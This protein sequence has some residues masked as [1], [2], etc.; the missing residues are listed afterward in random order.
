MAEVYNVSYT[1]ETIE[2]LYIKRKESDDLLGALF[3]LKSYEKLTNDKVKLYSYYAD[4]YYLL[5]Q[6]EKSSEYWCKYLC[7]LDKNPNDKKVYV[8]DA[9]DIIS[10]I[11]AMCEG[12]ENKLYAKAYAGLGA[13]YYKSGNKKTAGYYINKELKLSTEAFEPYSDVVAEFVEKVTSVEENYRLA[14]PYDKADFTLL[15]EE[16]ENLYKTGEYD[17]AIQSLNVIPKTSRFYAEKCAITALCRYLTDDVDGAI[18]DF[19]SALE[20]D[21]I[22][23]D[24]LCNA[25]SILNKL[26]LNEK[27]DKYFNKLKLIDKLDKEDTYKAI[28][29]YCELGEDE[30]ALKSADDY[31]KLNYYDANIILIL[32]QVY[33][34]KQDY[35]RAIKL[36]NKAYELSESFVSRFYRNLADKKLNGKDAP[37]KLEYSF[38]VPEYQREKIT[39]CITKFLKEDVKNFTNDD[40]ELVYYISDYAFQNH[41]YNI[42]SAMVKVLASFSDERSHE[43]LANLLVKLT[44]YDQIKT[45]ILGF[46]TADGYE[47][48]K[49]SV[50]SNI[51]KTIKFEKLV[52]AGSGGDVML[53]AYALCFAKIAPLEN[54]LDKLITTACV[55]YNTGLDF[56][57]FK[58]V[59]SLSAVI[60]ELSKIKPIISR[61]D[62]AKFFGANLKE[63]KRIKQ[64]FLNAFND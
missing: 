29:V 47:G 34:N 45:G 2:K 39:K 33:Y 51:Y 19:E 6:Y 3:A 41:S 53:E 37:N 16:A 7:E 22:N 4:T 60:F 48:I 20:G 56:T 5:N 32:G 28:L 40:I 61:R 50:F 59:N 8:A 10:Q 30:L 52:F 25:I 9:N 31:L 63:V 26:G 43:Y 23:V 18:T 36:F 24:T 42:Q 55:M 46:L 49:P 62:F 21:D 27:R 12:S 58:D 17:L 15:L 54:N 14:Y 35:K 11:N 13:V 64:L 57:K 1:E 38:D 44:V